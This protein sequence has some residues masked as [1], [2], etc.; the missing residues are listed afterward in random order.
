MNSIVV[1]EEKWGRRYRLVV[2]KPTKASTANVGNLNGNDFITIEYPI[3]L[4]FSVSRGIDVGLYGNAE[5]T[6]YNLS[7]TNRNYIYHDTIDLGTW[8]R[9]QLFVGYGDRLSLIFDGKAQSAY[10]YR[11]G[12]EIVTKISA[13]ET[14]FLNPLVRL[15]LPADSTNKTAIKSVFADYV[16]YEKQGVVS[17]TEETYSRGLTLADTTWIVLRKLTNDKVF[18]DKGTI[19]AIQDDEAFN[20]WVNVIS[21]D[22]G[23]LE[24]PMV[25]GRML[26]CKTILEPQI[27][28]GQLIQLQSSIAK[29]WNGQYKV[30]A[31]SHSG[32]ISQ[33]HG[34]QCVTSLRLYIADINRL[35]STV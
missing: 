5:L 29:K 6:L 31:L 10:S 12:T 8:Q 22:T 20:G 21:S 4:E 7:E 28:L 3:G 13:I 14:M 24:T 30:Q 1:G 27:I 15:T 34:G 25:F 18:I 33:S 2:W 17:V 26:Q 23:L 19:N 16:S 32:V 35:I 9:I 11:R